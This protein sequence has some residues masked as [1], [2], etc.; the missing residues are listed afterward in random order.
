ML[1][2]AGVMAAFACAGGNSGT[3]QEETSDCAS[4]EACCE[5][6]SGA[7]ASSC[8][9]LA[10]EGVA[11]SCANEEATLRSLGQCDAEPGSGTEGFGSGT[12]EAGPDNGG[13]GAGSVDSGPGDDASSDDD[14]SG[15]GHEDGGEEDAPAYCAAAAS[16]ACS[17]V[18]DESFDAGGVSSGPTGD[19]V[20]DVTSACGTA[21]SF[22]ASEYQCGAS[23][24]SCNAY[25]ECFGIS[26]D[27]GS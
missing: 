11:A 24:G 4:L 10:A 3:Q 21:P 26:A 12:G 27:G 6:L 22:E 23:A 15:T 9:A 14:A 25:F 8:S 16:R 2:V 18:P 19:C 17:C 20:S 1:G 7:A 13:S 5:Q